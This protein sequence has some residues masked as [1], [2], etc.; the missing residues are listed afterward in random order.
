MVHALQ[1]AHSL[2]QPDGLLINMH[3]LPILHG[4]EVHSAGTA[5]KAGWLLDSVDYEGERSA[6]NALARVV[7]EGCFL[8]EDEQDFNFNVH[9]DSVQELREWLAEGWETA[10]LPDKTIQR[11]EDILRQVG[12]EGEIVLKVP[13]RMTKL[14]VGGFSKGMGLS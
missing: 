3:D 14:R 9:V 11:V 5:I 13:A 12:Q 1:L 10:V 2:L 8:L 7:S 4:I 6:W